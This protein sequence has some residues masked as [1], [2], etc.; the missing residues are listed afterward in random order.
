MGLKFLDGMDKI[1][2]YTEFGLDKLYSITM[3]I[4]YFTYIDKNMANIKDLKSHH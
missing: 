2:E 4:E 3:L 1:P